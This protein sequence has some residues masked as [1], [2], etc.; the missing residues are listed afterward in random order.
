MANKEVYSCQGFDLSLAG[1]L[2]PQKI[3]VVCND[4][5][6][7]GSERVI[8]V[9]GPNQ[10]GK[11][12]FARVFGQ[13]HHL[14]AIGCIVPGTKAKSFLCDNIFTHFEKE[15]NFQSLNGKLADELVRMRD[16]LEHATG[17]SII[18]LNEFLASTT[19]SDA[20]F[21]GKMIM[22]RIERLDLLCVCETFLNELATLGEKTVS[23][24][25]PERPSIRTFKIL[26]KP[27][28]GFASAISIAEKHSLTYEH[29]KERIKT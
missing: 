21:I 1:K 12:T 8:V 23:T 29:I 25:I 7:K 14:A 27:A 20:F 26:R 13:L 16:I 28:D 6:L 5:Y 9:T 4:F 19:I 11:T 10:G 17:D 3:P 24:I 15:E 22:A 2:L 18:I